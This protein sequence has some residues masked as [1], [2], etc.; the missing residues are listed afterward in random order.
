MRAA[1]RVEWW[2]LRRSRV[3]AVATALM[4]IV[5][6]AMGLG[7]YHVALNGGTGALADKAAIFLVDE[8][9]VGFLRLIDQIAAVAVFLGV[10]VVAGWV[11]GR[12][13]ADRTFSAL[14]AL[15]VSRAVV[16]AAKFV[17]VLTWAGFLSVA[18]VGVSVGL[19]LLA[20]IDMVDPLLV[21][22]EATRLGLISM[23]AS[24][25]ALV[26]ALVAS[27]G[28]GYL[29]AIGAL[30]LIIAVTQMAVLFGTGAWFP[31]AVP[32]LAAVGGMEGLADPSAVQVFA[33]PAVAAAIMVSTV[34]WWSRAEV[35]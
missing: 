1:V 35:V 12:E 32:G 26:A 22:A 28:R 16:G 5:V 29:P 34:L 18:I 11:F 3:V 23:G 15:A 21:T 27:I 9:W 10:G 7:F 31:F 33:V 17:V 6:P 4:A 30:V 13:H 24:L 25:L 14:F 20:G 8:G 19:G 2:K